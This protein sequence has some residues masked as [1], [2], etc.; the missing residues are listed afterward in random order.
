MRSHLAIVSIQRTNNIRLWSHSRD[1]EKTL[2]S[3]LSRCL[4]PNYTRL[5]LFGGTERPGRLPALEKLT[6]YDLKLK[7]EGGLAAIG[8]GGRAQPEVAWGAESGQKGR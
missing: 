3:K 6:I 4:T 8:P 7:H 5:W 1:P 2:L